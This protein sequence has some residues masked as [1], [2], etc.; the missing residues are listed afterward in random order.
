MPPGAPLRRVLVP[1][2]G[3]DLAEQAVQPAAEIA[4]RLHAP[5]TLLQVVPSEIEI[6]MGS[7]YVAYLF[8][9]LDQLKAAADE[10]LDAQADAVAAVGVACEVQVAVGSAPA[11]ISEAARV[12]P[13]TLIV[14]SSHG[15]SGLGRAVLGSVA[16]RVIHESH[17]PV[18]VIRAA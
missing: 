11:Q 14:L 8:D 1:L 9:I 15:R 16:D 12:N 13:D 7:N 6:Y 2:D 3:S 4:R 18:L 10:Y 5:L 17:G